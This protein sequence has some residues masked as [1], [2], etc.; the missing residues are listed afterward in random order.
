MINPMDLSGKRILITGASSG[1]GKDTAI[2]LS[3]L[4][5]HIA[6]I[7]RRE[8]ALQDVLSIMEGPGHSYYIMDLSDISSIEGNITKI[9]ETEG[10]FDGMV[11]CAGVGDNRPLRQLKYE[12]AH[13][14]MLVSYYAYLELVRVM[15]KRGSYNSGFSIVGVSS[16]ATQTCRPSQTAYAAAKSAMD[17][18]MRCLA[19]E[20]SPKGIRINNVA[21]A[22]IATEMYETFKRKYNYDESH[23]KREGRMGVGETVDVANAIAFL[24]SDAAKFIT[25]SC[26][27]ISGGDH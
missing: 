18:M 12:N 16:I 1:I 5:A 17:A 15:T 10:S 21:P 14:I 24:L 7:A 11:H 19:L 22:M 9:I 2:Y 27:E 20:L 8:K 13:N 23:M 4:G 6:L 25:R 3:R 26:V